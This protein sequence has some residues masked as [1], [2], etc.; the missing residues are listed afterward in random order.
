MPDG[1]GK[2][3]QEIY[4]AL[5]LGCT[6]RWYVYHHRKKANPIHNQLVVTSYMHICIQ[7]DIP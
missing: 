5:E 4:T 6:H 3:Q 7:R 1:E 2:G